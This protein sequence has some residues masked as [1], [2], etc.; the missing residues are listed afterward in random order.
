MTLVV[1]SKGEERVLSDVDP[2]WN[3]LVHEKHGPGGWTFIHNLH[4][5]TVIS[6]APGQP[7]DA[8][9]V[10]RKMEKIRGGMATLLV[11]TPEVEPESKIIE[12]TP[13]KF[14]WPRPT[15]MSVWER[16]R[17]PQV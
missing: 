5:G 17:K 9:F 12:E 6:H 11:L 16:L 1:I 4:A 8:R 14:Q 2:R 3:V 7:E 10:V 13:T 15:P